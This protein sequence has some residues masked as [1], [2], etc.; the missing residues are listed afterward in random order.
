MNNIISEIDIIKFIKENPRCTM[1][2]IRDNFNMTGDIVCSIPKPNSK[3]KRIIFAYDVNR[4]FAEIFHKAIYDKKI[5]WC[6]NKF[7]CMTAD[8]TQYTGQYEFVPLT[9]IHY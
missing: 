2:E 4:Y 8:S 6:I 7:M 9:F 3:N 5:G 1:C